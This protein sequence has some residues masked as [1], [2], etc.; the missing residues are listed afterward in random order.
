MMKCVDRKQ[1]T[2]TIKII[3]FLF[4][5]AINGGGEIIET[6]WQAQYELIGGEE[7]RC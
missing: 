5:Q 7:S 6:M 1:S 3:S 4:K 2:E